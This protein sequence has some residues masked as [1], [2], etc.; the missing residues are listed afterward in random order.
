MRLITAEEMMSRIFTETSRPSMKTWNRRVQDG[1][2]PSVKLGGKRLFN[3][4]QVI[5]A[6]Q[7]KAG[8]GSL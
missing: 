7:A 5:K 4:S 6:I 2:I 3:E 1:S 8:G